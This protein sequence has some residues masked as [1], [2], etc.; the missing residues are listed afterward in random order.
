MSYPARIR[1][2]TEGD[3]VCQVC[4]ISSTGAHLRVAMAEV[5]KRFRLILSNDG[6]IQRD[7]K[8]VWQRGINI[9]VEFS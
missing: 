3:L 9:G 1:D 4:N 8:V 2:H 5:P 6:R 7:C